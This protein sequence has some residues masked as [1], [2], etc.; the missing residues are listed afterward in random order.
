MLDSTVATSYCSSWPNESELRL[1]KSSYE[2]AIVSHKPGLELQSGI[3]GIQNRKMRM[4]E[5][6]AVLCGL[7]TVMREEPSSI[8]YLIFRSRHDISGA[9]RIERRFLLSDSP[10][11][12]SSEKARE[13][14]PRTKS[15]MFL[16]NHASKSMVK[17]LAPLNTLQDEHP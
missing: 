16:I 5:C 13:P 4:R 2:L 3:P 14:P 12:P 7:E 8:P 17:F 11:E 15:D 10:N 6:F 9:T 1:L